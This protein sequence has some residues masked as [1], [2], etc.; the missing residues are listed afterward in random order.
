MKRRR[1]HG[2]AQATVITSPKASG[3]LKQKQQ[4]TTANKSENG[5]TAEQSTPSS[6]N[7]KNN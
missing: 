7:K 6:A 4:G 2:V 1:E 3:K 5:E